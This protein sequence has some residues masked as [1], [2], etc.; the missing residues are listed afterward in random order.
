MMNT[1]IEQEKQRL[2]EEW[3]DGT[4]CQCCN[5]YVKLYKRRITSTMAHRLITFWKYIEKNNLDGEYIH[6]DSLFASMKLKPC[7]DF[8]KLVYWGLIVRKHG[9][10]D[11]GSSR[12]GYYR[13]TADGLRFVKNNLRVDEYR[14]VFNSEVYNPR[15]PVK[16]VWITDCLNKHFNYSEL[17][18]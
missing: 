7:G 9:D 2:R 6:V 17:M 8:A 4:R 1:T 11:D 5:Q 12:N 3:Q 18:K 16:L 14:L 10:R 13:L 15:G